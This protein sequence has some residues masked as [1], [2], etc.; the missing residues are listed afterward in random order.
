M[1]ERR[2]KKTLGQRDKEGK[3]E[4][5]MR[6]AEKRNGGLVLRK[7]HWRKRRQEAEGGEEEEE[8]RVGK[9]K[10]GKSY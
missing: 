6:E 8:G 9:D 7:G 1:K 4:K 2:E 10:Q 5:E 3:E